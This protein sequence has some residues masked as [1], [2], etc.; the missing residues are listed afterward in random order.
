MRQLLLQTKILYARFCIRVERREPSFEVEMNLLGGT[1]G[2][3][4]GSRL[5]SNT[6]NQVSFYTSNT[7]VFLINTFILLLLSVIRVHGCH[8]GVRILSPVDA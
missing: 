6:E 7:L 1:E 3:H 2:W 5:I 4:H 8:L